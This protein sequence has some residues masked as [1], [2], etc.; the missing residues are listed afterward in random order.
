MDTSC[1]H[2]REHGTAGF[3]TVMAVVEFALPEIGAELDEGVV[4][5]IGPE[6]M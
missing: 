6:M 2:G 3:R 4:D 5:F 1:R